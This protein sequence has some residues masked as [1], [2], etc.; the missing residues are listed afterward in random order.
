L[1][2]KEKFQN[3][4]D[5]K[6]IVVIPNHTLAVQKCGNDVENIPLKGT[7]SLELN[8][9]CEVKIKD[10]VL[11]NFKPMSIKYKN[12]IL[13]KLEFTN[14]KNPLVTDLKPIKLDNINLNELSAVKRAIELEKKKIDSIDLTN[15]PDLDING[16]TIFLYVILAVSIIF[17]IIKFYRKKLLKCLEDKKK[18][19]QDEEGNNPEERKPPRDS[20]SHQPSNSSLNPRILF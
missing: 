13:P 10:I 9:Y 18:Q 15:F 17:L 4:A 16:W 8:P 6:W 14:F 2:E 5:N 20:S 1:S 3:I 7:Y 11:R 19:D 12:T